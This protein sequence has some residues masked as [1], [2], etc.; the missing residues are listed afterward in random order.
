MEHLTSLPKKGVGALS[1]VSTFNH[2]RAP[3]S[4]S[5][6][7]IFTS[8]I[9]RVKNFHG[10]KFTQFHSICEIFVQVDGYNRNETLE[11]S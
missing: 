1:S 5:D 11:R 9:I 4:R 2:K 6:W 3:M 8:K 10:I 7:Q